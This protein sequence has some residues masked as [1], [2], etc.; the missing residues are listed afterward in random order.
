MLQPSGITLDPTLPVRI[1][2]MGTPDFAVPSLRA[3]VEAAAPGAIWPGGIHLVG[4][5]TRPDRPSGR[6]Q[7]VSYSP[8]KRF[9]LSSSLP[10]YQPGSLRRPEAQRQLEELAPH[11]IVV[12]AFGQILPPEILRLPTRGCLNVHASLL[13]RWRGASPITAA[14]RAGDAESGVTIM[15]MDEG[16]DTGDIVAARAT[17]IAP[18]ETTGALT[19]RLAELGA[20][21]LID[22]LPAWLEGHASQTP[23]DETHAT[24][25]KPLRKDEGRLDWNLS[26]IELSRIV[27]AMSP[28]PGAFTTWNGKLLKVLDAVAIPRTSAAAP[29]TCYLLPPGSPYGPLACVCGEG[30]LALRVIQLEGKRALT[31]AEMLRGH[32]SLGTATLSQ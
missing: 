15:L 10:V 28:W 20:R 12:A 19:D 6:G 9:A 29:G 32:P 24:F 11:L 25:T 1:V 18:D 4:V 3:I 13:P 8:I 17:P 30:A 2:F 21:L 16:L 5:F 22:T 23:Q 26:A 14:I 27:R 7:Q 31:S